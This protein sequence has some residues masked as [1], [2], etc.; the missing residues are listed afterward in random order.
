MSKFD[1]IR[2]YEDHEVEKV[3]LDLAKDKDV[4]KTI[5]AVN[6]HKWLQNI[7]MIEKLVTFFLR[8]KTKNIKTIKDY[9]KFFES[10]VLDVVNKTIDNFSIEGIDTVSYTHLTLPTKA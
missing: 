3:L 6:K 4:I 2:P 1:S 9:Q 8:R 7:P 5:L 10:I